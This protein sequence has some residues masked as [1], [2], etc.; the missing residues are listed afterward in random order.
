MTRYLTLIAALTSALT[1]AACDAGNEETAANSQAGS[2]T[3]QD[4]EHGKEQGSTEKSLSQQNADGKNGDPQGEA[5]ENATTLTLSGTL[6]GPDNISLPPKADIH[7]QLIDVT[8]ENGNAKLLSEEVFDA[9]K[10][11]LPLPFSLTMPS[12]DLNEDHR[13]VLQAEVIDADDRVLWSTAE[14]QPLA[15]SANSEPDPMALMLEPVET[16]PNEE[17]E[18]GEEAV[19]P[20]D[21]ETTTDKKEDKAPEN[22]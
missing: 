20:S 19:S 11:A 8:L 14:P 4:T 12:Q 22:A 10:I 16:A 15:L 9:E 1:L 7:V 21:Q 3:N 18:A 13:Q 6:S 17:L 5:L 2:S